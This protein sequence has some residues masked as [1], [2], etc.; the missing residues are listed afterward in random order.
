MFVLDSSGSIRDNNPRDGSYDNWQL[1]LEFMVNV[2]DK[3][4]IG[5]DATRIGVVKF[6]DIGENVFFLDTYY[7]V[8]DMKDAIRNIPYVGSNT[9]TS[10]GIK[11]MHH[12][13]FRSDRGDR[14]GV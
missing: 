9:N 2:V 1:M 7:N 4:S 3:L 11:V 6:S 14:S 10:G 12:E 5:E 8:N 13:Q